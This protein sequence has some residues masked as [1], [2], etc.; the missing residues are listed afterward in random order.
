MDTLQAV[1]TV[2]RCTLGASIERHRR[3]LVLLAR[4]SAARKARV[5]HEIFVSVERLFTWFRRNSAMRTV[6]QDLPALLIILQIG[7]HDLIEDLFMNGLIDDRSERLDAAVQIALHHIGGRNVNR[8]VARW[9]AMPLTETIDPGML[10]KA[11]YD[12]L[13][14]DIFR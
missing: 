7:G 5:A 3:R 13:D 1:A 2:V 11:T 10:E 9:K 14:G 12:A 8:S 4:L 6:R